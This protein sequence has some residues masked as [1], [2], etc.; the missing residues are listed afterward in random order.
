MEPNTIWSQDLEVRHGV[1]H[2]IESRS[3][4]RDGRQSFSRVGRGREGPAH[5]DHTSTYH[6][7]SLPP[8]LAPGGGP[9]LSPGLVRSRRVLSYSLV[10]SRVTA[11]VTRANEAIRA[12]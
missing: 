5:M 9:Q 4:A 3:R 7:F 12:E 10:P 6:V 1:H 11:S 8:H 2:N